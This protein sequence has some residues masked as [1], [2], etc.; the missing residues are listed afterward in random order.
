MLSHEGEVGKPRLQMK[1]ATPLQIIM[2]T[3][4]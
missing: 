2:E 3:L 4:R 1:P